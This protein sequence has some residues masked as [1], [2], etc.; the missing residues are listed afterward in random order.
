MLSRLKFGLAALFALVAFQSSLA[1][2][3][4]GGADGSSVIGFTQ[5]ACLPPSSESVFFGGL[6]SGSSSVAGIQASCTPAPSQSIFFGGASDGFH[7]S[8]MIQ[9]ACP[10]LANETPFFGGNSDGFHSV[11]QIQAA[12]TPLPIETLFFGG[13]SD[14]FHSVT[15][16]QASCAPLANQSSY[17]GGV[18]DGFSRAS[19]ILCDPL[20]IELLDFNLR[21]TEEGVL[22]FWSTTSETN[23]DFFSV[24]RTQGSVAFEPIGFLKGAGNSLVTLRYSFTDRRPP[25]GTSYYRLK[26]TDFDGQFSYSTVKSI[27]FE[28]ALTDPVLVVFPNPAVSKNVEIQIQGATSSVFQVDLVDLTGRVVQTSAVEVTD[29]EHA[30]FAL[31][32]PDGITPGIY[33]VRV[34]GEKNLLFTKLLIR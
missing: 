19:Y 29:R 5:F 4:G 27:T 3:T 6:G 34:K 28:K 11:T 22:I 1:Q 21:A 31:P 24:E 10:P 13:I 26:Q 14:G 32:L 25:V 23:N 33:L 2:Y 7:S 30:A 12:C 8:G 9:S 15:Q 20:P 18:A 17:F 16:I